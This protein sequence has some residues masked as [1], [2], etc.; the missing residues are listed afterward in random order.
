MTYLVIKSLHII[1][2]IAWM[3]GMLYLPRLF[4]YH[5]EAERDSQQSETFKIMERKLLH[6]IIN[7]SLV[8]VIL[9]GGLL[10]ANLDSEMWSE[11]WLLIKLFGVLILIILQGMMSRWRRDF[12]VDNNSRTG[13]F[14]RWI[15]ELP[16]LVMVVIVIL[17]VV[18]PL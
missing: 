4:V 10:L 11:W 1:S 15:N 12:A 13:N 7:P 8:L 6:G 14:Y 5:C 2:V 9:F 16:A 17:V 3:A 18:K